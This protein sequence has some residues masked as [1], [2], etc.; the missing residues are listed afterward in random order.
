VAIPLIV[1]ARRRRAWTDELT[2]AVADVTW[3]AQELIPQ[4]RS[5][6]SPDQVAGGWAVGSGRVTAVEDRL[7]G[8]EATAPT[9]A[10]R[11]RAGTLREAV[12]EARQELDRRVAPGTP[13]SPPQDLDAIAS[14]LERAVAAAQR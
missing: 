12:R 14:R 3:F 7:V 9:D 1:R 10:D 8:L 4:L 2:A 6:G 13:A 5:V 11:T